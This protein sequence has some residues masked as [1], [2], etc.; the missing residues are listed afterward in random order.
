MFHLSNGLKALFAFS[1]GFASLASSSNSFEPLVDEVQEGYD[2]QSPEEI[3]AAR[4]AIER[5]FNN[6][7]MPNQLSA[8]VQERILS[9]YAHLDPKREVPTDLLKEAVLYF[10]ANKSGFPNQA[11]I[12]IVDFKKRSN[13]Q[14]FF[15]INME[16]G[17]VEKYRTTHG[18]NSDKDNDGYAESFGNVVNSGK[19]SLGFIRTAEVYWGK[20]KRSIRLDGLQATNSN[21]RARAIVYHG[22]DNVKEENRIQGRSW[23]CVTLDW[24]LKDA[25]LDKI[26]EGSLMYIGVS[27]FK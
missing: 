26:K 14:R 4:Q 27:K 2:L 15:I 6:A 17:E 16:T 20:Y 7:I 12:S 22:W 19:S 23:G 25:V 3:E 1:L 5:D 9:N 8:A 18:I 13:L 21:V 24:K 10:E 11:Y